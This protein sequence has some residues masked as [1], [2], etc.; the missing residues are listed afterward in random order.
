MAMSIMWRRIIAASFLLI[1][2]A[3][4]S[5]LL[6]TV[7]LYYGIYRATR[8]ISVKVQ[9]FDVRVFNVSYVTIE[10]E[11]LIQNPSEYAF[12]ALAVEQRSWLNGK[13][14]FTIQVDADAD[15]L[16]TSDTMLMSQRQV[17]SHLTRYVVE[18]TERIWIAEVHLM[19]KG[20][21]IGA[22]TLKFYDYPSESVH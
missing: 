19:I 7:N 4:T 3:M 10:T 2:A 8:D 15:V 9:K 5:M 16:P 13:Y 22:L 6:Y 12:Q 18:Q 21:L 11:L 14:I 1:T 20:P 17:P